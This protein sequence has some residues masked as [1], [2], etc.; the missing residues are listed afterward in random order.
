VREGRE[1]RVGQLVTAMRHADRGLEIAE[2]AVRHRD[3]GVVGFDLAGAEAGF[4]PSRQRVAFDY[5]AS[6]FFPVTVHAGEADGLESIRGALFDGRALRLG[7]GVRIAEDI[8]VERSDDEN[9]Y[10]SLGRLAQWVKDR[11]IVL[12]LSPSSNL[13]TGA[14]ERWGDELVDH[15]FDL[16]Y[17]LG[18]RV[19]VNVDNRT[20]SGTSLTRELGLLS[21]AFAYDLG[22]LEAFQLNAAAASF[23]PVEERED[24][25]DRISAGFDAAE[26]EAR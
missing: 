12:E 2:L 1:I 17:Q 10:V 24:L 13:Q 23:L 22:D 3:R 6:E 15:P 18:F 20:M 11:E 7:H 4:P 14:I 5:L 21:D 16:L 9:V 26:N 8:T 19:T 25:A